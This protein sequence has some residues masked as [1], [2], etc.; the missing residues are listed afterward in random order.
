MLRLF[1]ILIAREKKQEVKDTWK[2]TKWMF[3]YYRYNEE[4]REVLKHALSELDVDRCA[5][6]K[7]DMPYVESRNDY[8]FGSI[9]K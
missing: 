9:K 8:K 1:D 5:L 3:D 2:L 4:I 6:N 7:Y